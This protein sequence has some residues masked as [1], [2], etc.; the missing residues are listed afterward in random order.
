M[1][2]SADEGHFFDFR[3]GDQQAI[4]GI[5]MMKWKPGDLMEMTVSDWED[6]ESQ[7]LDFGRKQDLE[8]PR[9]GQLSQGLLDG[10]LPSGGV[11]D[12]AAVR[13]IFDGKTCG[14][15]ELRIVL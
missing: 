6:L 9:K 7:D 4:K 14:W 11:A 12:M 10:N 5:P 1:R 15:A 13:C 2:I 8:W 3:L